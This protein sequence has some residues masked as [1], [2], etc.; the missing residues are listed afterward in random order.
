V[1]NTLVHVIGQISYKKTCL[2]KVMADIATWDNKKQVHKAVA[3]IIAIHERYCNFS[4]VTQNEAIAYI[5]TSFP[6][7]IEPMS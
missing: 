3:E 1:R 5:R 7:L 6:E 2:A 4:A